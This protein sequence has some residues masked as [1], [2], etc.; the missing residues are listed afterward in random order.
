MSE[1]VVCRIGGE[2]GWAPGKI[3]ALNE[4]DPSDPTTFIDCTTESDFY[5]EDMS[6]DIWCD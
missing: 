3:Q 4:D 5:S 6:E 1:R 2:H